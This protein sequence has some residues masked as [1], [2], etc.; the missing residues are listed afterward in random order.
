MRFS[1]VKVGVVSCVAA[2]LFCG[3]A[4]A[5][6]GQTLNSASSYNDVTLNVNL[7][8][9]EINQLLTSAAIKADIPPEVVKAVAEKESGWKHF[10]ENG[11]VIISEDGG[12]GIMQITNQSN[13]DEEKLKTDIIY[14]INAGIEILNSMYERSDLPKIKG[15]DRQV[16]ENWYFPVMA[17][18][19]TK[20]VN[21]PLEQATSAVNNHAY[22]EQVF[23][24]IEEN[25]FLGGTQ[26][27][28]FPFSTAD[29][30]Y[31]PASDENITFLTKE[32]T[33]TDTHESAYFFKKDDRVVVTEE[34]AKLRPQ[35]STIQS[36]F[37]L[38]EH[39]ALVVTGDFVYDQDMNSENRFVWVPVKTADEKYSG[40][41]SSAY[42]KKA[43]NE[44][45]TIPPTS[46]TDVSARYQDAVSFV[47]SKGVKGM[48]DNTFG[49]GANIKRVDA[50]V[51]IAEVLDLDIESAPDS[52]FTDV[53]ERAVKHV[54]ALKAK[55]ITSG[56]T[57]TTLDSHS[58]ITRGELAIWI[59]RA[60]DLQASN[61]ELPFNDVADR[62]TEAVSALVYNNVTNGTSDTTFGT[63]DHAKRGDFALFLHRAAQ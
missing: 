24:F 57:A 55:G 41:I 11:D 44:P 22:Q 8:F 2:G 40:Y 3:V 38:S 50:A 13:Y 31:N 7:S 34:N 9:Q 51:M 16:I 14:N 1:I 45:E 6:T 47:V 48:P 62:Y 26:L 49:I 28:E 21:S 54:N 4:S 19:G 33:L 12:I 37:S 60:F 10:D 43:D 61:G 52:G 42:I 18:N 59:K 5:E 58:E 46:F 30:Q 63:H 53:P 29:F 35:P 56:K 32:Y 25:S 17:Y 20:P 15:A 27:G 23:A 36:G 39:T